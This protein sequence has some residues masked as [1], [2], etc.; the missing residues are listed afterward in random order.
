MLHIGFI[1]KR[2]N[3]YRQ[4]ALPLLEYLPIHFAKNGGSAGMPVRIH[5]H[6]VPHRRTTMGTVPRLV[7]RTHMANHLHKECELALVT[8]ER[9]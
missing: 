9:R 5:P 2:I 6:Q 8:V 7:H 3:R 4:D 1:Y